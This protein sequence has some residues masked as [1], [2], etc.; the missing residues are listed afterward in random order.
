MD[1]DSSHLPNQQLTQ[2]ADVLGDV[3]DS[4]V[5]ISLALKDLMAEA[6]SPERDEVQTEVERY[7]CRLREANKRNFD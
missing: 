1:H 2:L 3:R 5:M 6:A 7:L 4:W